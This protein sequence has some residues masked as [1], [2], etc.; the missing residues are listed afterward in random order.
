MDIEEKIEKINSR[1]NNTLMK[2]LGIEIVDISK[3]CVYGKMPVDER[4]VQPF[5]LLH[6]G[7]SVSLAESLGSIAGNM[8]VHERGEVVVGV[9][10]NANHLKSVREGWVHGKASPIR[11]GKKIQVWDI[12]ITNDAGELVCVSRLT[13]AVIKR[14]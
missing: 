14:N 2:S 13:V 6:G 4:T 11:I 5:G 1:A 12:Q 3:G 7:A 9:E 10:V 8:N